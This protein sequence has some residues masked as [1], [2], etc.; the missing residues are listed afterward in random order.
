MQNTPNTPNPQTHAARDVERQ[1]FLS[2][3]VTIH[4]ESQEDY[5]ATSSDLYQTWQPADEHERC[6]VDTMASCMWRRLRM[7]AF[8]KVAMEIQLYADGCNDIP[9][10]AQ[11]AHAFSSLT[12]QSGAFELLHRY[13]SR[14]LR[15]FERASRSLIAYRKFRSQEA[16]TQQP[17]MP[18]S[19]PAPA[20]PA[21]EQTP[22]PQPGNKNRKNEPKPRPT[23]RQARKLKRWQKRHPAAQMEVQ[24]STSTPNP[25]QPGPPPSK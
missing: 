23:G 17:A 11:A 16:P 22:P 15:A 1:T 5:F 3:L 10:V 2:Q 12:Q 9:D 4:G 8:E 6:L 20:S 19:A 25:P 24:P 18:E 21:P 14:Y 7:L 13:E